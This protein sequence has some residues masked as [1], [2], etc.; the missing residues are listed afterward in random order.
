MENAYTKS[1]ALWH[2]MNE[3]VL[4]DQP[5]IAGKYR[6]F[7]IGMDANHVTQGIQNQISPGN[8]ILTPV[9]IDSTGTSN[10][11]IADFTGAVAPRADWEFSQL[12]FPNDPAT[13]VTTSYTMHA[14]GASN[15]TSKGL[16]EGYA[17]SRSRP[18]I[19]DPN[20][21]TINGWMNDLFDD[22]EQL[23]DLK[24]II[25]DDNNRPPYPLGS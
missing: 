15:P 14:V 11:T 25:E 19:T 13:G 17:A 21:T 3:Q 1:K 23:D 8:R 6:D 5:S 20:V 12:T 16:I 4:D 2:E 7:K 18:Q 9:I 24:D 10:F 22:G